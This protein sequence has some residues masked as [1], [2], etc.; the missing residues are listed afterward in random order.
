MTRL[1]ELLSFSFLLLTGITYGQQKHELTVKEAVEMAYK[2]VIELKNAQLD[3]HIQEAQNKEIFGR[4]LPQIS[5]VAGAQYYLQ[6]PKFLFPDA[7][8]T[9]VYSI[10]KEE[11]VSGSNGPITDVPPPT[12]R[13]VSFQQPWN[14][15]VGATLQQL[16]FQPDVFVGLQARKTAL[17]LSA[18]F[19]E[20]T[21]EH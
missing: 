21:K 2:N 14:T 5:A 12:L 17:N 18:A 8:S 19:I 6:L 20:Q 15:A 7:T 13:E 16:L 10:L 9:A 3:Y 1:K 11:G 4:A